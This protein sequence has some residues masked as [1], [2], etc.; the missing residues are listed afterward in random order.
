M[1]DF[2]LPKVAG[3]FERSIA[4]HERACLVLIAEEQEKI[5]PN[6]AL[7]AVLSDSVRMG[8]EYCDYVERQ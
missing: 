5:N 1:E 3:T 2:K 7:I 4:D 6:N 8:R